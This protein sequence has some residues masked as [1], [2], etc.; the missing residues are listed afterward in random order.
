MERSTIFHGKTHYFDWAI[1]NSYVSSPEGIS[2]LLNLNI[3][4]LIVGFSLTENRVMV[5][6]QLSPENVNTIRYYKHMW[7]FVEIGLN[8]GIP[9][10]ALASTSNG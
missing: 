8:S 1:F 3:R 10:S 6:H 7:V 2:F 9:Y 5:D 4:L